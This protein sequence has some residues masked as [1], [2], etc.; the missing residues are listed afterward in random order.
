[1]TVKPHREPKTHDFTCRMWGKNIEFMRKGAEE[2]GQ[3]WFRHVA[4]WTPATINV[5]DLFK[6]RSQTNH[7]VYAVVEAHE[8]LRD[9]WDMS[10]N[11]LRIW[12]IVAGDG[13]VVWEAPEYKPKTSL[14]ERF[15]NLAR[16]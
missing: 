11:D 16:R 2:K 12:R 15:K 14:R 9:P 1:M 5:G 8:G 4:T 7:T 10:W 6:W 3:R 13:E